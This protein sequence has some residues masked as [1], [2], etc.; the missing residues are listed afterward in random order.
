MPKFPIDREKVLYKDL[1]LFSDKI[2]KEILKEYKP[3]VTDL[4]KWEKLSKE[5]IS[6]D[7]KLSLLADILEEIR[8]TK[9]QMK[10]EADDYLGKSLDFS[11]SVSNAEMEIVRRLI[12]YS[13]NFNPHFEKLK[14]IRAERI[15]ELEEYLNAA[16]KGTNETFSIDNFIYDYNRTKGKYLL[17][18]AKKFSRPNKRIRELLEYGPDNLNETELGEL[19]SWTNRRNEL[20][21]RNEMGNIYSSN[22]KDFAEANGIEFYIWR[23]QE[24]DRVREAH[25]EKNGQTFRMGEGEQPGDAYNCRC[26]MVFL[27]PTNNRED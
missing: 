2:L 27:D 6:K 4:K 7:D 21:A 20:M 16:F 10:N 1:K 11:R 5:A 19:I 17:N 23:T 25:Q 24:D 26:H 18:Q 3:N 9:I 12:E 13:T 15:K 8:K 22:C 14:T